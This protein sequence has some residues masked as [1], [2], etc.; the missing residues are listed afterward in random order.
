MQMLNY[1]DYPLVFVD[2]GENLVM[3]DDVAMPS[4]PPVALVEEEKFEKTPFDVNVSQ[5]SREEKSSRRVVRTRVDHSAW[6][7]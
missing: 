7:R 1:F 5:R 2:A 3:V 4:N 6:D